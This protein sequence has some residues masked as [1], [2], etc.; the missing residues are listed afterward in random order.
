MG[1]F[2]DNLYTRAGFENLTENIVLEELEKI[3][4]DTEEMEKKNI[5]NAGFV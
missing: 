3:T 4:K 1:E 2:K 5:A